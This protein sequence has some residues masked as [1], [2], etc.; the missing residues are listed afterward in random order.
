M[1]YILLVAIGYVCYFHFRGGNAMT[2]TTGNIIKRVLLLEKDTSPTCASY[3]TIRKVASYI[4]GLSYLKH[5]ESRVR[6]KVYIE[7][8]FDYNATLLALKKKGITTTYDALKASISYANKMI[9]TKFGV[10]VVRYLEED[11]KLV[12]KRLPLLDIDINKLFLSDT[13]K[14]MPE[15]KHVNFNIYDCKAEANFLKTYSKAV[16]EY[17]KSKLDPRK[18]AYI[19][20]LLTSPSIKETRLAL[21]FV[22]K[23]TEVKSDEE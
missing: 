12:E 5:K 10:S 19:R 17:E 13:V 3:N 2:D 22:S 15:H 11:Y 16:F 8:D 1:L 4:I 23:L 14:S 18:L 9:A 6:V 21:E 7:N 20:K